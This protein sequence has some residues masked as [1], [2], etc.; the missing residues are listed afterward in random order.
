VPARLVGL[1]LKSL[2]AWSVSPPHHVSS[3]YGTFEPRWTVLGMDQTYAT[4]HTDIVRQI[5]AGDDETS[6]E[7]RCIECGLC[8]TI[9]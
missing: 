7:Q 9:Q 1:L 3:Y 5:L 6:H 4:V 8:V 2:F